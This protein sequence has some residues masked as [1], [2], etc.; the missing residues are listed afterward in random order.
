MIPS[1]LHARM[2]VYPAA[3][4]SFVF[5]PVIASSALRSD[6]FSLTVSNWLDRR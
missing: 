2:R 6:L 4:G 1:L 5:F 3:H